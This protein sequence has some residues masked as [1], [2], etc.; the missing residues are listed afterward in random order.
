VSCGGAIPAP[1]IS[2]VER[3]VSGAQKWPH[4]A[5]LRTR[6][7]ARPAGGPVDIFFAG[8]AGLHESRY[9]ADDPARWV[10]DWNNL[11]RQ[12][13]G[14]PMAGYFS[15]EFSFQFEPTRWQKLPVAPGQPM[16]RFLELPYWYEA[17]HEARAGV[18]R[19]T[20]HA[21]AQELRGFAAY[22]E[23]AAQDRPARCEAGHIPGLTDEQVGALGE[24]SAE[25]YRAAVQRI[26]ED[27]LAGRYYELN[28]TQRFHAESTVPPAALFCNLLQR[29]DPPYAFYIQ[30]DDECIVSASPELFLCKTGAEV[31]TCPIKGSFSGPQSPAEQ[32]KLQ[33]EHIMVVDLARN[34]LGRISDLDW[35]QVAE[36]SAVRH[37]GAISHLESRVVAKTSWSRD[38]VF[39]ATFPAASITGTPKVMAVQAIAEYERSPRG[40]YT[41][42]CGVLWPDGDFQMNVAIRTLRGINSSLG[43]WQY[44]LGAGG[45]V[46]A[47][48]DPAAEYRECLAK[49]RPLLEISQLTV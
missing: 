45:A 47:D 28:F 35:V 44:T 34:D 20:A 37:F 19:S 29:L 12:N 7:P 14:A 4:V 22:V 32:E 36:Q 39:A 9:R 13:V 24:F 16:F 5:F 38:E 48:S 10:Q 15:Y 8:L 30:F 42:S 31:Q 18:I 46:V 3:L 26:R 2:D 21:S 23:A 33:A 40:I 6:N 41:G 25:E 11:S 27:I 17:D 43:K 49:V 1:Y